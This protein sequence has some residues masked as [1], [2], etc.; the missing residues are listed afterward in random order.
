VLAAADLM[1]SRAAKGADASP[2]AV[3]HLATAEMHLSDVVVHEAHGL[4][5]LRRLEP[6]PGAEAGAES[7]DKN[8]AEAGSDAIRLDFAEGQHLLVP[9]EEAGLI[10][11]YGPPESEVTLDRLDTGAW[12]KR[13]A[14]IDAD[15]A[16][17]AKALVA[18]AAERAA[19]DAPVLRPARDRYE[20][21][22]ARFPHPEPPDQRRAILAVLSDLESGRPMN[23]LVIGD[24]GF[25]KTEVALRAA[26]AAALS[27]RQV[28]VL[29]PS[30][31]LARQHHDTF[32]RRFA[33]FGIEVGH[34]SRLVP[35]G[36][37]ERVKAGLRDGSVQVVV[38]TQALLGKGVG[39]DRLALLV[40]DEEQRFGAAQKTRLRRLGQDLHVL[41]MTATPIP[42]TLQGAL[43]GLQALSE[44]ATPPARRRPIRTQI[45][46]SDPVTLRQA[47]LRETR[48]GGQSFVIVPRI[49]DIAPTRD[50]LRA[51]VPRLDLRIAHGGMPPR[52]IDAAMVGFADGAGDLLLATSIVENGLD[53]PRA[54]TMI[55]LRPHLFGLAQL[56]QIRGRVGRGARQAYCHLMTD[57]DADLGTAAE[58]RLGT[59]QLFDRL[60]AGAAISAQDMDQ[61][62][63]GDLIG[64]TQAGHVRH[65]G[66]GYYQELLAAAI[67]SA[68]GEE[69]DMGRIALNIGGTGRL[70]EDYI[71]E[72]DIRVNLYHQL[73]RVGG[74]PEARRLAEEIEDRFGPPPPEVAL[75]LRRAALRALARVLKVA[76]VQAGPAGVALDFR[77]GV[78]VAPLCEGQDRDLRCQDGRIFWPNGDEGDAGDPAGRVLDLLESLV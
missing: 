77:A 12:D 71:P 17:T 35:R 78:A 51:L 41:T 16:R 76:A 10:W 27:G 43:V 8:G 25:G 38:G 68:R 54:N 66:L 63:A 42:R 23:R 53:V 34:L 60:G 26:A 24:V 15:L 37:A 21:F 69:A 55:V 72:A 29:A 2:A 33:G 40:V 50:M 19:R 6:L 64:E 1:G 70:P 62:G 44:I 45:A 39:F 47:L 52:E 7:G 58:R 67:R 48:R 30:T 32:R 61:R 18:A 75:L 49:E 59:L 3:S 74:P 36:E 73:A 9:V 5:R 11:R 28:A 46:P 56:H 20:A 14:R 65:V 22:A 13:R 31:V 57:P 4:A